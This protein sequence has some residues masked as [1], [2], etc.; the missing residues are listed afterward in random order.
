MSIKW[1]FFPFRRE[2]SGGDKAVLPASR[3]EPTDSTRQ[4]I[5]FKFLTQIGGFL[6][7]LGDA[8]ADYLT[9][10]IEISKITKDSINSPSPSPQA[11]SLFR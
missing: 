3:R 4:Y 11:Q 6:G 9:N 1:T 2:S 8:A 10:T 7:A 5:P